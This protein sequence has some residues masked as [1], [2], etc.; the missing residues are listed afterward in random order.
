MPDQAPIGSLPAMVTPL[1]ADREIDEPGVE[2][3]VRRAVADGA[4]GVV[5]AGSTG[6]GALLEPEQRKLL[7]ARARAAIDG[8]AGDLEDARTL[9]MVAGAT[10]STVAALDA[11]V[12]RLAAAGADLVLVLAPS[13]YGLSPEELTDLH[14]G[15]AER[16]DVPTLVYHIPQLTGSSL[17]VEAVA[18]LARHP[19]IV[20]MKD[21]SPD[22]GRRAAFV[23]ATRGVEDFAVL[24]GHA[25]TLLAALRAGVAGS[26]TAVANLRQ[27]EVASLHA[28]A[29]AEDLA[30]ADRRQ[31]SLSRLSDA[32]AG[33]GASVPA[34][35]KAA[36]QLEG[37]VTERWCRPPLRSI[38]P[39]R[40]DRVRTALL[41]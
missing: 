18:E 33:V 40:L 2:A 32:I 37:V 4:N 21:S 38:D 3:L 34:V 35:L 22:A 41:R 36:L 10:G 6:E 24:T 11:D 14:V 8:A 23:E 1:T 19:R 30:Q 16:A 20:G 31:D 13:L 15:V 29:D 39:S 27:W 17:S 7:T 9:T 12:G 26:I 5:V 25:P 28:A